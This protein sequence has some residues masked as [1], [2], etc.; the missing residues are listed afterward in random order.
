MAKLGYSRWSG[1]VYYNADQ[2]ADKQYRLS[3]TQG[4]GKD[5]TNASIHWSDV[6]VPGAGTDFNH[7]TA[8]QQA[9]VLSQTG[10]VQYNTPVYY[11]ASNGTST[12]SLRCWFHVFTTTLD[13]R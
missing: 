5:Y 3:F 6:T 10:F 2:T 11:R 1:T 9:R 4:T 13:T 7:L 8:Q 12:A